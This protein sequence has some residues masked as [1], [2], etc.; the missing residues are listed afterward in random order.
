M[1]NAP[2]GYVP[3]HAEIYLR[4]CGWT[5][6]S[7]LWYTSKLEVGMTF[8]A[9]VDHQHREDTLRLMSVLNWGSPSTKAV[10]AACLVPVLIEE[11]KSLLGE[12][13]KMPEYA[14]AWAKVKAAADEL[15]AAVAAESM[16]PERKE[17]EA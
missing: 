4:M 3:E 10:V 7:G 6:H 12:V 14:D 9:A 8:D 1:N 17:P 2:V 15:R 5:V 16:V 13:V 11:A